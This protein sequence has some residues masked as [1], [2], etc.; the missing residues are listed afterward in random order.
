MIYQRRFRTLSRV[1]DL[2]GLKH[3]NQMNPPWKKSHIRENPDFWNPRF[4][5]SPFNWFEPNLTRAL[6]TRNFSIV[7]II[8]T[9][10]LLINNFQK[11]EIQLYLWCMFFVILFAL[12]PFVHKWTVIIQYL[13]LF[14]NNWERFEIIL[15]NIG[16]SL[17]GN[18][19]VRGVTRH[20]F[21]LIPGS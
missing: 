18:M 5:G 4:L 20:F 21:P 6:S 8:R 9:N 12:I 2:Y 7:S 3:L 11:N 13:L 19:S 17:H 14:E 15:R 10:F 16:L 1:F